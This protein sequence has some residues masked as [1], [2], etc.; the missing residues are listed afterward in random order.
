M[1]AAAHRDASP[2][3]NITRIGFAFGEAEEGYQPRRLLAALGAH[4][5]LIVGLCLYGALEL[6]QPLAE[7]AGVLAAAPVASAG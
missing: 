4:D 3:S 6:P 5:R 2:C 7:A 1:S